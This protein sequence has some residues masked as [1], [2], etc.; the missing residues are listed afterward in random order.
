MRMNAMKRQT[1]PRANKAEPAVHVQFACRA[2]GIPDARRIRRWA[3]AALADGQSHAEVTVRVVGEREGRLLN[4]RWRGRP[5]ATNV[6][7]F[8]APHLPL[9]PGALGDIAVCAPVA[10]REAKEQGKSQAAHWA[11]LVIHGVLHLLGHEHER[12]HDAVVME[13]LEARILAR[14]GFPDPYL[15]GRA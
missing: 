12:R 1:T 15:Q 9:A 2:A 7:S 14:L 11:H 3:R 4:Q 13:A 5:H 6:L 8:S 10:V